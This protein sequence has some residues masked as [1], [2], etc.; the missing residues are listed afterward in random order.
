[1]LKPSRA[2]EVVDMVRYS[3]WRTEISPR[4]SQAS[5][6][7]RHSVTAP[8]WTP[9]VMLPT[10]CPCPKPGAAIGKPRRCAGECQRLAARQLLLLRCVEISRL[11]Q[12]PREPLQEGRFCRQVV[13][14]R[15]ALGEVRGPCPIVAKLWADPRRRNFNG[16]DRHGRQRSP[17]S[18]PWPDRDQVLQSHEARRFR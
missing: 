4:G 18:R 14:L 5:T 12:V 7:S 17:Q 16:R 9:F 10:L 15:S 2:G 8:G 3:C 13:V 6:G 1:M 11:L